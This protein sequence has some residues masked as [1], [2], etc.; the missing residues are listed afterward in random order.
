MRL[1]FS[2]LRDKFHL[3]LAMSVDSDQWPDLM[4]AFVAFLNAAGFSID[5]D[6]I[7]EWIDEAAET[8]PR[9]TVKR[10]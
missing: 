4:T 3:P 1:R 9:K 7:A 10:A 2:R 8:L 6:N 5:R